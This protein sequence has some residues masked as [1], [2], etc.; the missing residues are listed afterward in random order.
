MHLFLVIFLLLPFSV[1]AEDGTNAMT[2]AKKE[3]D[4]LM[5]YHQFQNAEY[6]P[7]VDAHGRQ[8]KSADLNGRPKI[9]I[10]KEITFDLGIDLAEKYDLG[11][12]FYGK[13]NLGQVKIKG[14]DVYWNGKK[15]DQNDNQA[16]LDACNEQYGAK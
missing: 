8:V 6:V 14:R 11:A 5:K 15:L 4:R 3:C 16:V 1:L 12:G 9:D 7:G 13:A 10:P 2:I